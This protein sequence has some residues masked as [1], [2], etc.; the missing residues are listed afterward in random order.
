MNNQD[1]FIIGIIVVL[2]ILRFVRIGECFESLNTN[3]YP[4][5][6]YPLNSNCTCPSDAPQRVVLGQFPMNYGEK[7]PYVYTCV[8]P[9][10]PEPNTTI[11]PN[12]DPNEQGI[13]RKN[14]CS[15]N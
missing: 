3:N 7:S 12:Q 14:K 1:F 13:L 5:D 9:N 10:A 11:W 6:K 15:S 2:V 8:P 4:C